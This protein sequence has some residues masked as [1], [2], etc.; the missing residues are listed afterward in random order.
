MCVLSRPVLPPARPR[1]IH[2]APWSVQYGT[3]VEWI[4]VSR[5]SSE[6]D[7]G[8]PFKNNNRVTPMAFLFLNR[9]DEIKISLRG[10]RAAATS[11]P[12]RGSPSKWTTKA[13]R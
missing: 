6:Y 8:Y 9:G 1:A 10:G 5:V 3:A 2:E 12:R 13:A 4:R 11:R 7:A